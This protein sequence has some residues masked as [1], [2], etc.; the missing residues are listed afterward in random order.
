MN[1]ADQRDRAALAARL[2]KLDAARQ[3]ELIMY[4]PSTAEGKKRTLAYEA[5]RKD[6]H[7]LFGIQYG[8]AGGG[9]G[10]LNPDLFTVK[11]VK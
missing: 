8:G 1:S 11:P 6:L 9:G 3:T 2:E 5:K 10:T 4:P 7:D